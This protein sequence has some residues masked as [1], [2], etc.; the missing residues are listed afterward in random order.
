MSISELFVLHAIRLPGPIDLTELANG[1]AM[2]GSQILRARPAGEPDV[3]FTAIQ[4]QKP[5]FSADSLEIA[6]VL[7]A[8]GINGL[9]ISADTT[10]TLKQMAQ[11]GTRTSLASSV[12]TL[13]KI[14]SGLLIWNRISAQHLEPATISLMLAA[15]YNGSVDPL[16]GAN[17]QAAVG[18]SAAD[19]YFTCGPIN[20]NGT[21][22]NGI[23]SM[24]L[25]LGIDLVVRGADGEHWPTFAAIRT[26]DIALEFTSIDPKAWGLYSL[27]GVP[28]SSGAAYLRKFAANGDRVAEGTSEHIELTL[29]A[30]GLIHAR[31][32]T[33][34]ENNEAMMSVRVE[35][36]RADASTPPL[37]YDTT[38]SIA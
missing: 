28:L 20:L 23:Q 1:S 33:S 19:Q 15:L 3:M 37:T 7:D 11:K 18:V 27:N 22:Y 29:P 10:L 38:A 32:T 17:D 5:A 21:R 2:A 4:E 35:M 26:R 30:S 31:E 9:A 36:N 24:T 34:G 13:L 12:H 16:V 14:Q 8:V 6:R 25:D